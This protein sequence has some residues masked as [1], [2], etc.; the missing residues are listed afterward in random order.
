M[1]NENNIDNYFD[2]VKQNPPLITIE[3]V[4]QMIDKAETEV[5]IKAEVEVKKGH[6]NFLKFTIM[7]TIFAV[8]LSAVLMWQGNN[9]EN[10][11]NKEQ[12]GKTVTQT[13]IGFAIQ[14]K[15]T[16]GE[17]KLFPEKANQQNASKNEIDSKETN[18]SI[19]PNSISSINSNKLDYLDVNT[20]SKETEA[21]YTDST[22]QINPPFNKLADT[23]MQGNYSYPEQI[24]DSTMFIELNC[25]EL[26]NMGFSFSE[27]DIKLQFLKTMF[28]LYM[29][30]GLIFGVEFD[31][32]TLSQN[33]LPSKLDFK[34]ESLSVT[35]KKKSHDDD[36]EGIV[37]MLVTNE[38]GKE[39]LKV[40]IPETDLAKM[41]SPQYPKDFRTLL[42][43]RMKKNTFGNQPKEDLVYWFL[44]TDVFFN[45]LPQDISKELLGEYNY[46]VAEDKSTLA[47]PECKYFEECK[48]TLN[49]SNFKVF[50]NPANTLAT[51]SF[52]LN[53]AVNGRITL[54]DLAG[55][56]RQVLQ[57]QTSFSKGSHH[58][59]VDVSSVPEGI[60]LLTLY[61]NKG[62]QTQRLIVVR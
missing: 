19:V 45:R 30:E 21:T 58:I 48:N 15:E 38:N 25:K 52:T 20:I 17:G 27:N 13:E 40:S 60:Y 50:P 14:N 16:S 24:L 62:I 42:P 28:T 33:Q 2:R 36:N 12:I 32:D 35:M 56:E 49:S 51:L 23:E 59:E 5:K 22:V 55:H 34:A 37:P 31:D 7:T 18:Q 61:S 47:K 39:L 57:P 1:K 29:D 6:R 8:I 44:P 9:S 41:F 43:V 11:K 46:V 4:R 3:K 26:E 10:Q 53:E 54:V